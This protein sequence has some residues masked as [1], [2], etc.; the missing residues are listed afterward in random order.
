M[1]SYIFP[2]LL[3]L[4]IAGGIIGR[5]LYTRP[6]FVQGQAAADFSWQTADGKTVKLTDLRGKYVLLDFWGS[7]CGPC[8]QELPKIV[9]LHQKFKDKG[10]EVVSIAAEN[11]KLRW[12][13]AVSALAMTWPH[14]VLGLEMFESPV[15]KQYGV[16]VI[17]AKFL[18]NPK[19]DILMHNAD[20]T[21]IEQVLRSNLQ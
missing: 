21:Q 13:R 17:P 6:N 19:G 12:E 10:F 9:A 14:Q 5:Y 4:V 16:R 3:L 1:K 2:L 8:I 18:V 7:W 20:L 11:D 15:F